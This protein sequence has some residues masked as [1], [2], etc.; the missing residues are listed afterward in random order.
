MFKVAFG[1]IITEGAHSDNSRRR[2]RFDGIVLNLRDRIDDIDPRLDAIVGYQSV[3]QHL[4]PGH[5][6]NSGIAG[7]R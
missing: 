5:P 3:Q 6:I 1:F 4:I 2:K 7:L